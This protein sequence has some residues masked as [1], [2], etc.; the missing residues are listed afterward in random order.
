M[1]NQDTRH[2]KV[3]Y[4]TH[5]K[6]LPSS[7]KGFDFHAVTKT[8]LPGNSNRT[9]IFE[10]LPKQ[11]KA[12]LDGVE[13][14]IEQVVSDATKKL[15]KKQKALKSE[16]KQASVAVRDLEDQLDEVVAERNDALAQVRLL[17]KK[18]SKASEDTKKLK[19]LERELERI[20]RLFEQKSDENKRMKSQLQAGYGDDQK[21]RV[22]LNKAQRDNADLAK[23][24]NDITSA[25]AE[26]GIG[27]EDLLPGNS[28]M[29]S[30]STILSISTNNVTTPKPY[31][32]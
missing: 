23:F 17:T 29:I 28:G 19:Y 5:P 10:F 21:I 15:K 8:R 27:L 12:L 13:K 11:F 14:S 9:T 22:N 30:A 6:E 24:L 32:G 4:K 7:L 16:L 3:Y 31:R 20:K 1:S 2:P 26:R 18:P 25:L